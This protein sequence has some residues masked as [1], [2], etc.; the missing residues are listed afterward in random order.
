MERVDAII[1]GV[2]KAGTTSLYVSLAEHPDVVSS[3]IKETRY[4]LPARYGNALKPVSVW[5]RYFTGA[6]R[7][8]RLEATPSYFYGGAAVAHAIRS[9]LPNPKIVVVLREPV[10]RA[11]SFF[12]YQKVRLRLPQKLRIEDYIAEVDALTDHDFNDPKNERYMAIRGGRYADW[13][14]QWWDVLGHDAVKVVY[15]EDLTADGHDVLRDVSAV[16]GLDPDRLVGAGLRSENRTTS[17]KVAR[18]QAVALRVN[19]GFERVLRKT[20]R[21]KRRLRSMYFAVNGRALAAAEIPDAV[22]EDLRARFEEPNRRL[23]DLLDG[24]GLARP[25]WLPVG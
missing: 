23:G 7:A 4:F 10:S 8:V 2:N 17:F 14:A 18:L 19:D 22:A 16:L 13:L 1:A 11:I 25:A 9:T 24:A 21:M 3:A 20:P 15:F 6:D 12:E 5:D